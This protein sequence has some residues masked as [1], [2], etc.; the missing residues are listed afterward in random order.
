MVKAHGVSL[1]MTNSIAQIVAAI[2]VIASLF[3]LGA[4][5]RQNT[6][7]QRSIVVD[8]LTSSLIA[9][10]GP[11][12]AAGQFTRRGRHPVDDEV[13]ILVDQLQE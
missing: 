9:L 1:E 8:S 5:I 2:G 12:P 10:L 6:K 4:Q 3:Y 7:S 13:G 11:Q